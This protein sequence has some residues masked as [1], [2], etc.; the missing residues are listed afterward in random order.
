MKMKV[1]KKA[2]VK[3]S[4]QKNRRRMMKN[5]LQYVAVFEQ[6]A[7]PKET[8]R[9]ESYQNSRYFQYV[10]TETILHHYYFLEPSN[11]LYYK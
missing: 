7:R 6:Y 4:R 3:A 10:Q 1:K 5:D 9:V 2:M 8:N 11:N